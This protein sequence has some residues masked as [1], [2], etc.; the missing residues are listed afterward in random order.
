[1]LPCLQAEVIFLEQLS[2]P[3]LV[4]LVGYCCEDD[5][6]V[7]V[8]EFMPLRSVE[9]HLFS[10]KDNYSTLQKTVFLFFKFCCSFIIT[11]TLVS[12]TW[13]S[14]NIF[15]L[16][17]KN[18]IHSQEWDIHATISFFMKIHASILN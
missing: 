17:A 16:R 7:L 10:S 1:L 9:S 8:Y 15:K 4:K 13:H 6:R 2:H 14:C 12:S 5:H 11:L 18:I 3:N